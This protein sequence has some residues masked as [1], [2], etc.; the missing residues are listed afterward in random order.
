V[1]NSKHSLGSFKIEHWTVA[2][3]LFLMSCITFI[4]I[5]SRYFF[6]FSF[7]STEELTI[8]MFVWMT[9]AGSGIAFSRSAHLGMVSLFSRFP[10]TMKKTVVVLSSLLSALLFVV[11]NVVL[12]QSI[13]DEIMVFHATSGAL[14][15]PVWIYYAGVPV[16]SLFVFKGI[17]QDATA[18]LEEV[19]REARS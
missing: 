7:A 1:S 14:G 3:L 15:I 11:V 16:M 13:R 4:N 10:S 6:H 19:P 5:L 17:Y 18:K 12:I 8:N 9:V 2:L